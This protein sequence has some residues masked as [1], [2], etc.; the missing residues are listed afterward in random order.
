MSKAKIY[1]LQR[2]FEA[3]D[4]VVAKLEWIGILA[5]PVMN[6]PAGSEM[7]AC[8]DVSYLLAKGKS[9]RSEI[10]IV[11]HPSNHT[12]RPTVH[13][14]SMPASAFPVCLPTP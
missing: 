11:T 5:V 10:T 3:G 4:E 12:R 2:I 14:W 8:R 13:E 7:K 1:T 9:S 6:L